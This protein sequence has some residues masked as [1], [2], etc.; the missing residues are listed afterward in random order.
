[1]TLTF[2]SVLLSVMRD[3]AFEDQKAGINIQYRVFSIFGVKLKSELS[4]MVA[5]DLCFCLTFFEEIHY[6]VH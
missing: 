5:K 4:E 1:M 2:F 6:A 3:D